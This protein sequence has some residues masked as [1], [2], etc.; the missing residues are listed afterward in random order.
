MKNKEVLISW[1]LRP[2]NEDARECADCVNLEI[3]GKSIIE[4]PNNFVVPQDFVERYK[5]ISEDIH[6]CVPNDEKILKEY[7]C[8]NWE[9]VFDVAIETIEAYF[10]IKPT[11]FESELTKALIEKLNYAS[12]ELQAI[13]GDE[14]EDIGE[15]KS[16]V[17]DQF[18]ENETRVCEVLKTGEK[19]RY[20]CNITRTW[21][22]IDSENELEHIEFEPQGN[23]IN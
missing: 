19:Y 7:L 1:I 17:V 11:V 16:F 5:K 12:I 9:Y 6:F 2:G 14:W 13:E 20:T 8:M 22:R 3:K 23:Q 15:L 18:K 10:S 4:I 21:D